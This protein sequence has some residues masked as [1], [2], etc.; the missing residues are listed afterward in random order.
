MAPAPALQLTLPD[1]PHRVRKSLDLSL[2][3]KTS[4][5]VNSNNSSNGVNANGNLAKDKHEANSPDCQRCGEAGVECSDPSTCSHKCKTSADQN[6]GPAPKRRKTV[7]FVEPA[8]PRPAPCLPDRGS[9]VFQRPFSYKPFWNAVFNAY[10]VTYW[11]E[12]PFLHLPTL[13]ERVSHTSKRQRLDEDTNLLLLGLLAITCPCLTPWAAETPFVVWPAARY[14]AKLE[15]ELRAGVDYITIE[16]VQS[17]LMLA[18]Y[19]LGDIEGKNREKGREVWRWVAF[20]QHRTD[21]G[22]VSRH[23]LH[24]GS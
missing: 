19:E 10:Q 24:Q 5:D 21:P 20:F 18:V 1:L 11:H 23:R 15:V 22:I 6:S 2:L 14:A 17:F 12:L 9:D 3:A 7:T 16:R 13:R 8:P 4:V